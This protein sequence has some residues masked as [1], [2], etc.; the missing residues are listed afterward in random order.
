MPN[1]GTA[2]KT[3][4][5]DLIVTKDFYNDFIKETNIKI[6][7]DIFRNIILE[8]N[9]EIANMVANDDE[10][11]K[12]P[13]NMGYVAVTKY[14]SKKKPIDW[15]NSLLLGK[16]ITLPN[17][18]SFGYIYHIHWF[19]AGLATFAFK[20]IFKLEPCRLLKREVAKNAKEG[21]EYNKWDTSDFWSKTKTLRYLK[22]K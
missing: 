4:P 1:L 8:S 2:Y 17:L 13:E 5:R 7:Y 19:K 10:S 9:K 18:H 12:L 3:G 16:R 21:K 20:Q 14:K 11:F 6:S 15:K 22:N